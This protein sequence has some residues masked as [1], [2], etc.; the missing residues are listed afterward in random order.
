MRYGIVFLMTLSLWGLGSS[1]GAVSVK[2]DNSAYVFLQPDKLAQVKQQLRSQT[3]LPQT[4]LAYQQLLRAA[5]SAMKKTDL[6]VT[7]KL[8]IPPGSNRHDYLSLAAYWW[9][10]PLR[11]DGLPWIRHDGKVN[12]AT[13]GEETDAIRLATFTDQVR[14]L[15]LAWY[16][17]DRP[18]YADKAISMI[19]TWF[20][21]PE[22]RMNPNL[23]YAQAIPGRNDGRGAGV[24]DGRF[25]ATRIVDALIMLRRAPGW[26]VSD[27]QQMRQWMTDYLHW[28]LTSP[29]GRQEAAAKNNHGSW[30]TVQ[31]AGIAAYLGQPETV[32]AMA[33]LQRRKLDHQLAADGSQPE[34]LARTRSFHY[35][36]FNLQAVSLMATVAGKYGD[37][38]WQYRTPKGSSLLSA[39]DFMA[40]YLDESRPWPYKTMGRESSPLIP[41]MLQAEQAIGSPR[42]HAAIRQAGFSPLLTGAS[43]GK[44]AAGGRVDARRSIWL[45]SPPQPT[46]ENAPTP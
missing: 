26:G 18:E 37:N 1:A 38:L 45:L 41:L 7:Q 27:E 32:R 42:Y 5:D 12:P 44:D 46:A 29:N 16:F 15:S 17:S 28:L 25:F 43:E 31:V 6:S 11:K 24:L 33:A 14:V 23:N 39:L 40:P 19:R 21:T 4:Q 36:G 20:I 34:E 10:D 22:T 35:S 9:P 2:N 8:S 3:A 30:Y 13:K